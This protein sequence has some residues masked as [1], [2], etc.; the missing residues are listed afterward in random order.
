ML[1]VGDEAPD[2]ELAS[3]TGEDVRLSFVESLDN[4]FPKPFLPQ[5]C[6]KLVEVSLFIQP[7]YDSKAYFLEIP[8]RQPS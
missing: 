2:F 4:G 8:N 7:K 1:E 5:P 6:K 3:D